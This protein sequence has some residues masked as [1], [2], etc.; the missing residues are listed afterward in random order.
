MFSL[1][2]KCLRTMDKVNILKE[3]ILPAFMVMVVQIIKQKHEPYILWNDPLVKLLVHFY[4]LLPPQ[5]KVMK[6]GIS[7]ILFE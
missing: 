3:I 1:M 6:K 4:C 7:F 2:I 5:L